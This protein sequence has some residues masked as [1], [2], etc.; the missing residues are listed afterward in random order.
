M[1]E[2]RRQQAALHKRVQDFDVVQILLS[3][4]TV[5]TVSSETLVPGDVMLVPKN[6]CKIVCDAV[7]LNG[8]CIA[9]ESSLTGMETPFTH[10]NPQA[11]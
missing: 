4:G 9:N 7:L 8:H 6:G 5:E 3:D 11:V 1:F 10:L 2:T